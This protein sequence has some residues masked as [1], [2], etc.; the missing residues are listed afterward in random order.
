MRAPCS[1]QIGCSAVLGLLSSTLSWIDVVP[2]PCLDTRY[3]QL[4]FVS[5]LSPVFFSSALGTGTVVI[6]G[7]F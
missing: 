7:L 5:S 6:L 3:V 2:H 1:N 4:T